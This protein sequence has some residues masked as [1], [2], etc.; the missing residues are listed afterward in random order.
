MT[1]NSWTFLVFLAT[2]VVAYW[3]LGRKLRLLLIFA[4][5]L[6]FYGFWRF[7]FIPVMLASVV[8]DYVAARAIHRTSS[9]ALRRLYLVLSL[10]ANLGL[11]GFF[12]YSYF[13]AETLN[14]AIEPLEFNE[15]YILGTKNEFKG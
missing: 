10:S 15:Y 11:L 13:L 3:L 1:F 4:S 7:E 8:T 9:R 12:K 6:L 2:F 5:S 14:G